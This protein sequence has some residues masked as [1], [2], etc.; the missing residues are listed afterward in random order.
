MTL[1]GERLNP[2]IPPYHSFS[3]CACPTVSADET[4]AQFVAYVPL[5]E[6]KDIEKR[7]LNKKKA[8]LLSKYSSDSLLEQQASAKEFLN[9]R[10]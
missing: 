8:D 1:N 7:I 5:P 4:D 6:T 10:S 9:K 3:V 2:N